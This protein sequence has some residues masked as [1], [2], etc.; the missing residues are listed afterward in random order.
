MHM[1]MY[2]DCSIYTWS[3]VP[4]ATMARVSPIDRYRDRD[5][6]I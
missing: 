5:I 3:R 4:S 2:L 1:Y 6:Y